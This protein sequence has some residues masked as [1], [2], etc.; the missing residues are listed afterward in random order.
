MSTMSGPAAPTVAPPRGGGLF[1]RPMIVEEESRDWSSWLAAALLAIVT[2]YALGGVAHCKFI[3]YSDLEFIV[4]NPSVRPGLTSD[5]I[6]NAFQFG[7]DGYAAPVGTLSLMIDTEIFGTNDMVTHVINLLIHTANV[8]LLF[9]VLL[10]WTGS[11]WRSAGCAL[12]FAVHPLRLVSVAWAFERKDLLALFFGLLSL[13][14]YTGY[15]RAARSAIASYLLACIFFALSLGASPLMIG[16]PI[17][18]IALDYWPR[19]NPKQGTPAT[20]LAAASVDT[21]AGAAP[22]TGPRPPRRS[23]LPKLP[24]VAISIVPIILTALAS[25]DPNAPPLTARSIVAYTP[26]SQ[27]AASGGREASDGASI[28][29][30]PAPSEQ[31]PATPTPSTATSP[32]TTPAATLPTDATAATGLGGP[33]FQAG[34]APSLIAML[35]EVPVAYVRYLGRTFWPTRLALNYP[36]P[37]GYPGSG[38]TLT[39]VAILAAVTLCVSFRARAW[40]WL[41]IGW[42]WYLL[43][44]IAGLTSL[45]LSEQTLPDQASYF[46]AIG[47]GV[48]VIWSIPHGRVFAWVGGVAAMVVAGLLAYSA[49]EQV[50]NWANSVTV[51]RRALDVSGPSRGNSIHLGAALYQE[52]RPEEAIT[53]FRRA[54]QCDPRQPATYRRVAAVLREL[55]RPKEALAECDRGLAYAASRDAQTSGLWLERARSL[56]R[57]GRYDDAI[58]SCQSALDLDSANADAHD[59][60]GVQLVRLA[61]RDEAV[62][63]FEAALR[64]N[65]D[66]PTYSAHLDHAMR[67]VGR[68]A[69][70]E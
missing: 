39:A 34:P 65:P 27:V 47:L 21:P 3:N 7:T 14:C 11:T 2:L 4:N 59:E 31:A 19:R 56:G 63:Q 37:L 62:K 41:A 48:M 15:A 36:R 25:P 16:L 38:R 20:A 52:K 1:Q 24:F 67:A 28:V 58:R 57:L 60:M 18:L 13:L 22:A 43:G 42:T 69:E 45:N 23:I 55:R 30:S 33:A 50:Q 40:P 53:A 44:P 6:A 17:L 35:P 61:R 54:I 64:I 51:A 46:G 49:G 66:N 26:D 32:A 5:G 68:G 8:V 12:L 10:R 29:N 9:A 70:L